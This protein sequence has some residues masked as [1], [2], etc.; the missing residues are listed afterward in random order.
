MFDILFR[1]VRIFRAVNDMPAVNVYA[2]FNSFHSCC[3]M[4]NATKNPFDPKTVSATSFSNN[5]FSSSQEKA[6][7]KRILTRVAL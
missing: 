1:L 6:K 5:D 4:V 2:F 3:V 7:K